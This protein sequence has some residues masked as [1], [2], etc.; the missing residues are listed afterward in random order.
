MVCRGLCTNEKTMW[1]PDCGF[2]FDIVEG[3]VVLLQTV[4][5]PEKLIG[6]HK[7]KNPYNVCLVISVDI[8]ATLHSLEHEDHYINLEIHKGKM[9]TL[10]TWIDRSPM[11][12]PSQRSLPIITPG[13]RD[14]SPD[15]DIS[16]TSPYLNNNRETTHQARVELCGAAIPAHK[17]GR[18]L[19]THDC[20]PPPKSVQN[21]PCSP[22]M[23]NQYAMYLA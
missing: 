14:A 11:N 17:T 23:C 15:T 4:G 8:E 2:L 22:R 19:S 9:T 20:D 21:D 10:S 6:S 1:Y 12:H 3:E 16:P 13:P 5:G 18:A 7:L